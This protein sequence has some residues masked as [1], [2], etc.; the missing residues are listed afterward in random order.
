MEFKTTDID[1][2]CGD[3]NST[4]SV[5]RY[6]TASMIKDGKLSKHNSGVYFTDIPTNAYRQATIDYKDAEL[7]GYFKIDILN[8]HVYQHITSEE[9]LVRLMNKL[10][11]WE[12]LR[13]R[14]FCNN[15]IHIGNH[16]DTIMAMP[17]PVNSI[18]RLAMLLAVIRPG[19]RHLIGKSWKEVAQ[20]VWDKTD[21][22]SFKKSHSVSYAHL[23]V[24]HMNL[25]EE[26]EKS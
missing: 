10:P 13:D 11:N 1:I 4:L 22:Y 14:E 8:V 21:E 16:H 18:P 25:L 19:K 24:V 9:H 15:I 7:R 2:D 12:R 20:T 17:E 6:N 26:M 23:V 3:R 5:F